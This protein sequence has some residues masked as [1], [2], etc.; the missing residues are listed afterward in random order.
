M[1]F[2]FSL[3]LPALFA[4]MVLAE[5]PPKQRGP[6]GL[7][8]TSE[9]IELGRMLFFDRRLS[10]DNTISCSSCHDPKLGWSDGVPLAIGIN[11]LVGTR[12]SPTIINASY[13]PLMFHDGRTV[14]QITQALLPLVNPIEMGNRSER[15]VLRKLQATP[16]YLVLFARTFSPI[17]YDQQTLNPITARNLAQAIAAFETTVTSFNAPIDRYRDGDLE[18]L[19]KTAEVGYNIF[20]GSGCMRCHVPPLYTDNLFHNNGMEFAGKARPTDNGRFTVVR[21]NE[22]VR[23][24]KTPTLREIS[25]TAPYNH[26]GTYATLKRVL[27]HYNQ[28]GFVNGRRDQ[29]IDP[30][31][32]RLNL[33]ES[34]LQHLE[35]FLIEAFQSPSYPLIDA[36]QLP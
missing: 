1:R 26:A 9:Q 16:G 36:P 34:Q 18:A 28:G 27:Q 14:G 13:S 29:F 15:D 23:A 8:P 25:R 33:T 31:I 30:R 19:S 24:F 22:N 35:I 7:A 11:G 4:S 17:T 3:L 20:R 6:L 10:A 5:P 2:L 21:R 32:Q 12:N